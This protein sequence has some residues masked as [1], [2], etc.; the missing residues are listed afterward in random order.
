MKI[1]GNEKI[2]TALTGE[3]TRNFMDKFMHG[4]KIDWNR[5]IEIIRSGAKR[6]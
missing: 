5:C 2:I 6:N 4:N 1:Q 3:V